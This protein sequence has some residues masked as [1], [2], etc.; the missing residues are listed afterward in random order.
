MC[1]VFNA[2]PIQLIHQKVGSGPLAHTHTHTRTAT[3]DDT[4]GAAG[5]ASNGDSISSH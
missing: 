2:L 4:E 1:T 5:H 3:R